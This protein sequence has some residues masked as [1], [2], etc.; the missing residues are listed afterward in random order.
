MYRAFRARPPCGAKGSQLNIDESTFNRVLTYGGI[1]SKL[2]ESAL[3]FREGERPDDKNAFIAELFSEIVSGRYFPSVP[4]GYII[5][6]KHNWVARVVSVFGYK[7]ACLYYYC[8]KRLEDSIA[9]NHVKGTFGGWSMGGKIPE[10]EELDEA[11]RNPELP[12]PELSG[13]EGPYFVSTSLVPT[14]WKEHW[15]AFQRHA[16]QLSRSGNFGSCIKFDI[17]NFYDSINLELLERQLRVTADRQLAPEISLLM[18]FLR[19]WNRQFEG[20]GAKT[21]GI[22]QEE[23]GDCSRLL[24]NFYLQEYDRSMLAMSDAQE[25]S[26]SWL[27]FADDQIIMAEHL[28]QCKSMLFEASML[29]NR[30]GLRVNSGKVVDFHSI[31]DFDFYWAF[32]LMDSLEDPQDLD[33]IGDAASQFYDR[34]T[35]GSNRPWRSDMVLKRIVSIGI[36]KFA[37]PHRT[38]ILGILLEPEFLAGL[39][40]WWFRRLWNS[41]VPREKEAMLETLESLC[42]SIPFTHF[43]MQYREFLKKS[44][45]HQDISE[46]TERIL[47]RTF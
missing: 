4:R 2:G 14:L 40:S 41:I 17:A 18:I 43:H 37:E 47:R 16:Y 36:D 44:V 39:E 32:D 3:P 6:D 33:K 34:W 7:E 1:Y 45:P 12:D 25:G 8:T 5:F 46:L 28:D 13:D 31:D 11:Q 10:L 24:A 15:R 26:A 27:R 20:Y 19:N 30:I 9:G 29:L 38:A 21:V 42:E 35:E 22:P 23:V